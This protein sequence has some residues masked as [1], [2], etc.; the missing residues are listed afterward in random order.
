MASG[1]K[2]YCAYSDIS[3]VDNDYDSF[4]EEKRRLR[5]GVVS[6]IEIEVAKAC[7]LKFL[8]SS[9]GLLT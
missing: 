7:I 4:Q 8:E 5:L 9:P 3:I 1:I 2:K 6:K